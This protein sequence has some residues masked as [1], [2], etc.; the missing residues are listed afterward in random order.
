MRKVINKLRAEKTIAEMKKSE[1][2]ERQLE[3]IEDAY[4]TGT[5]IA[6]KWI[7]GASY[8]EIKDVIKRPN[9]NHDANYFSLMR[10]IYFTSLEKICPEESKRFKW[11]YNEAFLNGW[12]EEV[13]NIWASIKDEVNR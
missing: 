11:V 4:R 5:R 9:A 6:A 8:Q 12:R 13:N 10:S 7:R 1:M 2:Q 3:E